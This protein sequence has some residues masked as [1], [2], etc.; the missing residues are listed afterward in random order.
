MP[1]ADSG[2]AAGRQVFDILVDNS[3]R[4][5][6]G[7][8]K[9]SNLGDGPASRPYAARALPPSISPSEAA[10]RISSASTIDSRDFW[11][12][13]L[14][15]LT[16]PSATSQVPQPPEPS[17]L[18]SDAH[19]NKWT[20]TSP[21]RKFSITIRQAF[22]EIIQAAWLPS[23]FSIEDASLLSQPSYA[24][25]F[26]AT[27]QAIHSAAPMYHNNTKTA[28]KK[29]RLS[30][31]LSHVPRLFQIAAFAVGRHVETPGVLGLESADPDDVYKY[32]PR[33]SR[34]YMRCLLELCCNI[35]PTFSPL[36]LLDTS[37]WNTQR[38]SA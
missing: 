26:A 17:R 5:N 33:H 6:A 11:T 19:I 23:F 38:S 21:V 7:N 12:L 1:I 28:L 14:N 20:V 4:R 27:G 34:R 35:V 22:S 15:A 13:P 31:H 32:I 30:Q 18:R 8:L 24:G 29:A 9:S 2:V 16:A 25:F 3:D 36:N 37:C 10:H